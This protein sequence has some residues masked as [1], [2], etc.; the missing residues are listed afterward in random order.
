MALI[1]REF[2][3][4]P[5]SMLRIFLSSARSLVINDACGG[6][7]HLAEAKAAAGADAPSSMVLPG[8]SLSRRTLATQPRG[9]RP[10]APPSA[11]RAMKGYFEN[12]RGRDR[13]T[14]RSSQ[15]GR[16]S[17]QSRP[18][19]HADRYRRKCGVAPVLAARANGAAPIS[20]KYWRGTGH[21]WR[22]VM[23]RRA[24]K[25]IRAGTAVVKYV[26][27]ARQEA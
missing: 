26:D 8:W 16:G 21:R 24:V 5:A 19:A 22:A 18:V 20:S 4:S 25:F 7:A 13:P 23:S 14:R 17:R 3:T 10:D 9:A 1:L 6:Y 2:A 11:S 12:I 15:A 27:G